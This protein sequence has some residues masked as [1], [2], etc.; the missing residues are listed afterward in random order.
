M[1]VVGRN[2]PVFVERHLL[3]R[4]PVDEFASEGPGAAESHRLAD[5]ATLN[6]VTRAMDRWVIGVVMLAAGL[7]AG[8]AGG[9]AVVTQFRSA[10][11]PVLSVAGHRADPE[12]PAGEIQGPLSEPS[13]EAIVRATNGPPSTTEQDAAAVPARGQRKQDARALP[14]E[15]VPERSVAVLYVQSRPSGAQ[16]Y[17]DDQLVSTTP[18]QLSG[19]TPGMHTVRIDLRGYPTWSSLVSVQRGARMRIAASL[20]EGER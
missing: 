1:T 14:V 11:P 8:F 7:V 18:F 4:D 2:E 19:I 10:N 12:R 15:A 16:V 9:A 3:L 17:L 13:D 5:R 6:G 20:G